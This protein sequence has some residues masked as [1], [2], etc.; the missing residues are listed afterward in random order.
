MQRIDLKS[1]CAL[2]LA[3]SLL[4]GCA[5]TVAELE[6]VGDKPPFSQVK[7]PDTDPNY[8]AMT[9]P[10][11]ENQPPSRQY[12]NTLWQPGARAFFRDGRAARV[13]DIL[14]VKVRIN[15]QAQV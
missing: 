12:A 7:N 1:L 3:S 14:R 4:S 8:E 6:Q 5:K 13:G 15:D 2:L 10:M 9:W 11:P